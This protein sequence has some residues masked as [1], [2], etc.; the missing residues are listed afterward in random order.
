MDDLLFLTN[1]VRSEV[2]RPI[3][4]IFTAACSVV[5]NM[6]TP[7]MHPTSFVSTCVINN[8]LVSSFLALLRG[9]GGDVRTRGLLLRLILGENVQ[10]DQSLFISFCKY[11]LSLSF[12]FSNPFLYM[13]TACFLGE[14]GTG[15]RWQY[16][17]MS[18]FSFCV[19]L[20]LLP[21]LLLPGRPK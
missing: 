11:L 15:L 20:L 10:L 18:V 19:I 13:S 1:N 17:K 7:A 14:F 4:W 8:C 5:L 9:N 3:V 6:E 12:I 2:P 21:L 16:H